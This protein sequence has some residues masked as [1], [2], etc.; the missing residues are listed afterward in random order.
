MA[1]L[2]I[3][4]HEKD[5]DKASA[6]PRKSVATKLGPE[7]IKQLDALAFKRK[8]S[9]SALIRDVVIAEL[10]RESAPPPIDHILS[11]IVGVRLLLV[12]LLKPQVTGQ[13]PM[14]TPAFEALL[15]EIRKAKRRLATD[16]QRESGGETNR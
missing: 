12:N 1:L 14:T 2:T 4:K 8:L 13:A 5:A 6:Y 15:E 7:E 10:A 11:E 9:V 16:I 3:N